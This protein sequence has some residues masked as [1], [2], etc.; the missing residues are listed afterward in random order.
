MALDFYY[1]GGPVGYF[2]TAAFPQDSGVYPYM[3][4]R[5]ASHYAMHQHLCDA[6]FADCTYPTPQCIVRFRVLSSPGYGRLEL[7]D[8]EPPRRPV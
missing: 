4:Y 1:D 6:G 2:E 7:S 8:F 3:P 5:S